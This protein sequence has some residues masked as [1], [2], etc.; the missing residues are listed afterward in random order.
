MKSDK[1]SFKK[2]EVIDVGS[3]GNSICKN[4]EGKVIIVKNGVPGDI[5]DVKTYKKRKNFFLGKIEKFHKYSEK[6]VQP[7][8]NHFGVCGGCKWQN[9][10]YDEQVKFKENKIKHLFNDYNLDNK[11]N[12]IIRPIT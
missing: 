6:R 8:C 11:I 2:I 7:K 9:I 4:S 3:K 5:I 1:F 12:K 10:S